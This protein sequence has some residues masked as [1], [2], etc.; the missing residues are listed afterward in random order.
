LLGEP[1]R[2]LVLALLNQVRLSAAVACLDAFN[3]DQPQLKT[4][5]LN[6]QPA[7]FYKSRFMQRRG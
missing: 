4:L 7:H 5:T 1:R 2:G 3:R 6:A